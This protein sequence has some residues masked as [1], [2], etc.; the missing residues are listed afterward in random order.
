[1]QE[2]LAKRAGSLEFLALCIK[3]GKP[4]EIPELGGIKHRVERD[5][6]TVENLRLPML[7][8]P[9]GETVR[10]EVVDAVSLGLAI[11]GQFTASTR[12]V[13]SG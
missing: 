8:R 7:N 9:Q 5:D 11:R 6:R 12:F 2:C 1:M 3:D 10:G 13:F 4:L